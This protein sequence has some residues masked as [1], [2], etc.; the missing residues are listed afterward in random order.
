MTLCGQR[1]K[2]N[3]VLEL[4]HSDLCG[5]MNIQ[6]KGGFECFIIFIDNYSMYGYIYLMSRKSEYFEKF[7]VFK[8]EIEKCHDKC[9]KTLRSDRG[10]EYLLGEFLNYLSKGG[11]S[12]SCLH[13]VCPNRMV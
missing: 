12:P 7:R 8:A 2:S 13:Q 3:E 9:I 4:V 10:S 6:A 11:L 1:Q 5:P